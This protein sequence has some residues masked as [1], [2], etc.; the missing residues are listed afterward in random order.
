MKEYPKPIKEAV[1]A[2][3]V[4]LQK[5]FPEAFK[6]LY[7]SCGFPI[8][9]GCEFQDR[10]EMGVYIELIKSGVITCGNHDEVVKND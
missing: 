4:E 8:T 9:S 5:H 10:M 3:C 7:D 2:L 6:Q 1:K